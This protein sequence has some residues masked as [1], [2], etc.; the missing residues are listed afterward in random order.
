MAVRNILKLLFYDFEKITTKEIIGSNHGLGFSLRCF[1]TL[2]QVVQSSHSTTTP[3]DSS[4]CTIIT[5][6][7]DN[8]SRITSS[9][10]TDQSSMVYIPLLVSDFYTRRRWREEATR[11]LKNRKEIFI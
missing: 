7:V 1:A 3:P 5:Y 10:F 11:K 2:L 8:R 4:I 9:D 6:M